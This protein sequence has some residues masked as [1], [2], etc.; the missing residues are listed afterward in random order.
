MLTTAKHFPGHGDTD[1]DSHLAV[2]TSRETSSIW[3]TSNCRRFSAAIKAGVDAV[4]VAHVAVPALDPDPNHVASI[5]P[6]IVTGLL[7]AADGLH[8]PGGHR[9]AD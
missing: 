6:A 5:S 8:R 3:K 1:T 7:E 4:M 9:C 2:P